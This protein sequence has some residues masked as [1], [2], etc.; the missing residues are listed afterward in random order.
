[1]HPVTLMSGE[2]EVLRP[3]YD[4]TTLECML[5]ALACPIMRVVRH[6]N[7]NV[8]Y[9]S[10]SINFLQ[11]FH[12][13]YGPCRIPRNANNTPY[14]VVAK[15]GTNGEIIEARVRRQYVFALG[16]YLIDHHPAYQG[17]ALDQQAL[18]ALPVNDVWNDIIHWTDSNSE[19]STAGANDSFGASDSTVTMPVAQQQQA[20]AISERLQ[21]FANANLSTQES[22]AIE[23]RLNAML[24]SQ[25]QLN[26]PQLGPQPMNEFTTERIM[27]MCFPEFF[28]MVMEIL[29]I[30]LGGT[31]ICVP[32][33]CKYHS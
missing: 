7:G 21:N 27:A 22:D 12:S 13:F 18:D 17:I 19:D 6:Q 15:R 1:M 26:W 14:F 25:H 32:Y 9:H 23:S 33:K 5:V 11:N 2:I 16:S 29:P 30:L 24:K 3:F 28:L 10:Y 20:N 31:N 4:T 8:I